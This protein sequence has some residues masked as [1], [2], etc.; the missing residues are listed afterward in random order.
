MIVSLSRLMRIHRASCLAYARIAARRSEEQINPQADA[1]LEPSWPRH[2][3]VRHALGVDPDSGRFAW[4]LASLSTQI[5]IR[6]PEKMVTFLDKAVA[7][8]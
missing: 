6:L 1:A 3:P 8:G 2:R 4:G 5:A 7:E